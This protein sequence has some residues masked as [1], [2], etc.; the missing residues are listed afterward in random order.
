MKNFL[1]LKISL[2]EIFRITQKDK[3]EWLELY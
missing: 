3:E 2:N 1:M